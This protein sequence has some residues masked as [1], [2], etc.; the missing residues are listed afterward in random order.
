MIAIT[1][2]E[3]SWRY[4][5]SISPFSI[6]KEEGEWS[7][8]DVR[9]NRAWRDDL[10]SQRELILCKMQRLV[11]R[12]ISRFKRFILISYLASSLFLILLRFLI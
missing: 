4:S 1:S 8:N 2:W 5:N 7:K 11:S 12:V 6:I 10:S 9:A 3:A